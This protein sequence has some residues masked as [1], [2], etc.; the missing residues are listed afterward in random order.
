MGAQLAGG[1]Q[2][3]K[4]WLGTLDENFVQ[5]PFPD[6]FKNTDIR[7]ELFLVHLLKEA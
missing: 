1:I 7:F 6:G 3:Q 2:R 4:K 5:V